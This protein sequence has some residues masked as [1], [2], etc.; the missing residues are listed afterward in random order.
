[1]SISHF[2]S[3][4]IADF[5]GTVTVYDQ[6][7]STQ[8]VAANDLVRPSDWNS[9]HYIN[10]ALSGNTAGASTISGMDV[11][12]VGGN[13][14]T[15]SADTALSQLV[16][17]AAT[18]LTSQSNQA[19]SAANGSFTFQTAT[20]A[21]SNGVSFSTGTQGIF[22]TVQTNYLT[23]ARASNDAVGLNTALTAGPLAWTVNSN[24]ISLNAGSAAGTT[25]GFAGNLISGSMTHN[26]AGLNLSL[27]HPAWLTTARASNDAVGLNTAET[28][29]T[30]TVNSNGLSLNASGYAGTGTTFGGT[31]ISGSLTLNSNGIQM[32]LSG[33]GGGVTN[34]TG[35]NIA[36]GTQTATSGT[37]VFSN[38]NNVTFGM[39]DSSVVTAS[40]NPIN[41]GVSTM[42]NTAGTTGTI[43]G[44]GAQ[45]LFVG[46]NG[47][48][49]SQ[50]VNG[51]SATVSIVGPG[52]MNSGFNPYANIEKLAGQYGNATL[53][54]D[55]VRA[56]GFVCDRV[57]IP[58]INTNSSNSSGSHTLSFWVG[59]YTRNDSTLSLFTSCSG[60]TAITH[61]GT[62]GSYSMYSGQRLFT[63]G[64][65]TTFTAG[66]YWLG[67]VSRTTSGGTNGSYSNLVASNIASNF[68]GFFGSSHNTTYQLILG[69]GVYTATTSG[70]PDSVAFSQIRGSDSQARRAAFIMFAQST[71]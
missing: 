43:D 61:S 44:A 62:A 65:T 50:S 45:F 16:I 8:T 11:T 40:F 69:Q 7:G 56:E 66:D 22:A 48:T 51:S 32:S 1:M 17:S 29:V 15:L 35:P 39:S 25:S 21:N 12:L 23:T 33:G 30:W 27:N 55:P 2:K 38:S 26:T 31:N 9:A 64:M 5:T 20:F 36:A 68:L 47:V 24:G 41:I 49:L 14:I 57:I 42:G 46:T 3:D 52:P 34:Q 13:N 70:I 67:F 28:N 37:V 18:A 10:Y 19:L 4:P 71:I 54:F 59:M 60:S 6:L 53:Q 63:I 58:V